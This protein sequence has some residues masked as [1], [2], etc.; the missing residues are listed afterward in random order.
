MAD[1]E[2]ETEGAEA[3]AEAPPVPDRGLVYGVRMNYEKLSFGALWHSEVR[4]TQHNGVGT[5]RAC[6]SPESRR[7]FKRT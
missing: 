1:P 5:E 7:A 4:R 2:P 3:P 6:A